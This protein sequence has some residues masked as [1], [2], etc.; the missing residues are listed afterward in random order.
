M[1]KIHLGHGLV[2]W[3]LLGIS[4]VN[5]DVTAPNPSP[6]IAD[7]MLCHR[8]GLVAVVLEKGEATV[9]LLWVVRRA[10]N[11]DVLETVCT[12]NGRMYV[13]SP[14]QTY[15][16][17]L[18]YY[19]SSDRSQYFV[20]RSDINGRTNVRIIKQCTGDVQT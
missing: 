10:V 9:L 16:T 13:R 7:A 20:L 11:D 17:R 12:T 4:P 5:N 2:I 15:N 8:R 14:Q 3:L 19:I 18:V 1:L 6:S